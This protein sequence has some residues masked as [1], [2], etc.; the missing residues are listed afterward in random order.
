MSTLSTSLHP[1]RNV[2]AAAVAGAVAVIGGAAVA[3]A[4]V[5]TAG[6]VVL[7]AAALLLLAFAA[8]RWPRAMLFVVAVAPIADRFLIARFMPDSVS[9]FTKFFSE[10]LLVVVGVVLLI[11]GLRHRRVVPAFRSRAS[12]ALAA[13]VLLA[14]IS[15]LLNRVPPLIAAAGLFYTLDAIAIFYLCRIVG[16]DRRQAALAIGGVV[17]VVAAMA[18][19]GVLQALFDPN[20]F[21]LQVV[22]GRS[23]ES[24][25]VGS[26]VRDPNVLGTLIGLTMPFALFGVVHFARPRWRWTAG[27]I[28]LLM[29]TALLLTYSRGSWL[30]VVAGLAVVLLL[31]DRRVFLVAIA[32]AVVALGIAT[33]MPRDLLVTEPGGGPHKAP[34]FNA[35]D[36]TEERVSAVGEGRDLRTLF[37][38]NAVPILRDH[39]LF[40]VGPGRYGGAVA[41][42]FGTPIYAEYGTGKLLTQQRTVDNFW[43]HILVEAG[44]LGAIAFIGMIVLLGYRL[45]RLALRSRGLRYVLAAGTL[46]GVATVVVSTGTTMLLEGNT[47]AF[48]FWFVLS[49]GSMLS[50]TA[51]QAE[52]GSA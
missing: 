39:P 35:W 21:G 33:Y 11:E 38:I 29:A 36:T 41:Y 31:L 26:I 13:F 24:V 28:A 46:G 49:I 3:V 1:I 15:A 10:T 14:L 18:L 37:V 45:V 19:V 43:L 27:A 4:Y 2:P 25:R 17:V 40:G 8:W 34:Q 5:S 9:S 20:L 50:L 48:M 23:G 32:T 42:D 12:I 44:V 22:T 52:A 47:V 6:F 51:D 30:G 7:A 16:F